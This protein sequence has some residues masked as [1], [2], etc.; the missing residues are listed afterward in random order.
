MLGPDR[1]CDMLRAHEC[2]DETPTGLRRR[3]EDELDRLSTLA[4][5]IAGKAGFKGDPAAAFTAMERDHPG[6]AELVDV[7]RST[8]SRL[9]DFWIGTGAVG[10]DPSVSCSVRTCVAV[11]PIAR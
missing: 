9:R 4:V 3:A 1:L 7:A 5:E 8:L 10:V 2:Q 6:A 11:R